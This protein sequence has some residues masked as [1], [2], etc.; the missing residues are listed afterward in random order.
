MM[1]A[2]YAV[3]RVPLRSHL[4]IFPDM[5]GFRS[6]PFKRDANSTAHKIME[7]LDT[8]EDLG[9]LKIPEIV[10]IELQLVKNVNAKK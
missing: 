8:L 3:D 9:K 2:V 10:R 6:K 7:Y 1:N 4:F 5:C